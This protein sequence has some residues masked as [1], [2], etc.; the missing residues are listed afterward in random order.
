MSGLQLHPDVVALLERL[1]PA[2]EP[3][4]ADWNDVL[5]RVASHVGDRSRTPRR[6]FRRALVVAVALLVLVGVAGAAATYL[7]LMGSSGFRE[8]SPTIVADATNARG[9]VQHIVVLDAKGRPRTIWEC[10]GKRFCGTV[11]SLAWAPS[12]RRLAIVLDEIGGLSTYVGLRILDFDRGTDTRIPWTRRGAPLE[13][14]GAATR[15]AFGCVNPNRLAWSPNGMWLAYVCPKN[16][17]GPGWIYVIRPDGTGRTRLST[18]LGQVVDFPSWSRDG[19]IAF[20]AKRGGR[21]SS[22]Y[23]IGIDG[24]GRRLVTVDA[25]APVWSPDGTAIA[26]SSLR[27][28]CRGVRL[29]SAAVAGVA[30]L[31]AGCDTIG[32]E[33]IPAW[34]PDSRRVAIGA[35]DGVYTVAL[36]GG[37]ARR[38]T[39]QT[40]VGGYGAASPTWAPSSSVKPITPGPGRVGTCG[41]DGCY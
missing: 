36:A 35:A 26:Y 34:S 19:R 14:I 22:V 12:G 18:G 40:G 28:G 41:K 17:T 37:T 2:A 20:Q 11:V 31:P 9:D 38:I 30:P 4:S 5:A 29:V 13:R 25:T 16:L 8:A 21:R 15:K 3:V 27:R 23:V 10:P 24:R 6:P 1:A 39:T 33:G 32:P 7:A